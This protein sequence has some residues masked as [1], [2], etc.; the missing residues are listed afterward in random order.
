[1]S[2]PTIHKFIVAVEQRQSGRRGAQADVEMPLH[3]SIDAGRRLKPPCFEPVI[4]DTA[5][6]ETAIAYPIDSR[7]VEKAREPLLT[8][9]ERAG[10]DLRQNYNRL[11]SPLVCQVGGYAHAKQY[12]R[13]RCGIKQQRTWVGRIVL[14]IER[15]LDIETSPS[16]LRTLLDGNLRLATNTMPCMPWKSSKFRKARRERPISS[17]QKAA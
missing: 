14:D 1:M 7:L 15:K 3:A 6:K 16:R 10:V 2:F 4:L 17:V 11:G 12:R 9:A 8:E 13:M 5:V